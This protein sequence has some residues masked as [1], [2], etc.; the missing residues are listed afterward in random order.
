M[1]IDGKPN[2]R[3]RGGRRQQYRMHKKSRSGKDAGFSRK[4]LLEVIDQEAPQTRVN[5]NEVYITEFVSK[6][7]NNA[8]GT[9]N[10]ADSTP[11]TTNSSSSTASGT[12]AAVKQE[13]LEGISPKSEFAANLR[14]G[15]S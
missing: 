8:D 7:V 15:F 6:N 12:P 3:K 5:E 4:T 13:Q 10:G 1:S 14:R 11:S 9:E 2:T